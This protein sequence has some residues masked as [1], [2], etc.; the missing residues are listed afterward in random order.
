M[1]RLIILTALSALVN[2]LPV[3]AQYNA[4]PPPPPGEM[5]GGRALVDSWFRHFLHRPPGTGNLAAAQ[6]IDEGT[7]SPE[8]TLAG[9]LASDEYYNRAGN[10]DRRY[11]FQLFNDLAGRPPSP[12][13]ADYWWHRLVENPEGTEGRVQVAYH[14]ILR[15]PQGTA[16]T[17][18]PAPEYR[19]RRPYDRDYHE[20]RDDRDRREYRDDRDRDDRDR[21]EYRR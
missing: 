2:V 11:L 8:M 4:P 20:Y 14:M 9:I 18:P 21:R 17:P 19:Y 6:G 13:E 12:G 15:Y 16:V 1:R 7:A 5:G 10:D 3:R